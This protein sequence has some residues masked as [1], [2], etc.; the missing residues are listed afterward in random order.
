M[1]SALEDSEN[2]DEVVVVDDGS[3]DGAID[4]LPSDRRIRVLRQEALGIVAA[5]ELGRAHCRGR[6]IRR[7]DSDDVALCGALDGQVARLDSDPGLAVVAG[8]GRLIDA[9]GEGMERYLD[10][11]NRLSSIPEALL[12][13][14]PILHPAACIRASMLEE[15]GGYRS[16]LFP[17]D[18]DLWLR[19]VEAGHR[20][21]N[22]CRDVV[23]IRD[24]P[25]RLTRTDPRY[26]RAN[27]R[28]LKMGWVQRVVLP[29]RHC[30]GVWGAGRSARPWIRWLRKIAA[31]IELVIDPYQG[32][33][34]SGV[35]VRPATALSKFPVD[36][37][38][39]AVGTPD[40]RA[41]VRSYLKRVHPNLVEGTHWFA[42]C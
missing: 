22:L 29:G 32:T 30:L 1:A 11:V 42:V 33:S 28:E 6:F 26:G 39:V 21:E 16:G 3:T 5:L 19:M 40:A 37:L 15:V 14:S 10:W 41:K 7:L 13:E 24:H 12:I 18:Y 2:D 4:N 17:E 25:G 36:L 23:A 27:F 34:R 20:L 9:Q 35:I 31:P 38:L 8:R